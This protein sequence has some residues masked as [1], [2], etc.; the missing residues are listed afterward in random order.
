M[1]N[2]P[3]HVHT[4]RWGLVA[5]VWAAAA[6]SVALAPMQKAGRATAAVRSQLACR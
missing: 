3:E 5:V 2:R 4:L 1:T 6:A